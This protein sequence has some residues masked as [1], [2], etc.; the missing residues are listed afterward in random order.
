MT[1][2]YTRQGP[3]VL[4]MAEDRGPIWMGRSRADSGDH[5]F[6]RLL[7]QADTWA[8]LPDI[9]AIETIHARVLGVLMDFN[10]LREVVLW[11]DTHAE[12]DV[13]VTKVK[14]VPGLLVRGAD[15]I[16]IVASC[17]PGKMEA[18]VIL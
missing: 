15:R 18:M 7:A 4:A 12:V 16:A 5:P 17:E 11:V 14:H 2:T 9:D 6:E 8:A 3:Y 1:A 13:S 10:R